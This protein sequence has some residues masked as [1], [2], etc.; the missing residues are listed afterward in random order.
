MNK[1]TKQNRR[2]ALSPVV[3]KPAVGFRLSSPLLSLWSG[4]MD[5]ANRYIGRGPSQILHLRQADTF[6]AFASG[7]VYV[8]SGSH[9]LHVESINSGAR[10]IP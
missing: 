9:A 3:S 6:S 5:L 8:A 4:N 7:G 1:T 2:D 10:Q